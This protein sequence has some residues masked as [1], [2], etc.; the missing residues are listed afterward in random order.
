LKILRS[1][2]YEL[3]SK[4]QKEKMETY[5]KTKKDIAWGSQIRSYVL[6]PYRMVKDHRTNLEVGNADGVLD[7]DIDRFI[8]AYLLKASED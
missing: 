5:H 2:L 3:E 7:G 4:K 6:H 1:R 8:Q